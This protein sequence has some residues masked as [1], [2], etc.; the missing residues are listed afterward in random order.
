MP[1]LSLE[2]VRISLEYMAEHTHPSLTSI[3]ALSRSGG[4]SSDDAPAAIAFGSVNE[5]RLLSDYFSP[6]GG[7]EEKPFFVPFG[8]GRGVTHW[9]NGNYPGRSLQR[10]RTDRP[11]I[12]RQDPANNKRWS[13]GANF[14]ANIQA[15]PKD[16]IGDLPIVVAH[17][18][19][20]CFRKREIQSLAEIVELF[21]AEFRLREL[22]ALGPIFSDQI[23]D[24]LSTLQLL[25]APLDDGEL[26]QLLATYEPE[27]SEEEDDETGEKTEQPSVSGAHVYRIPEAP[28]NWDLAPSDLADL[29][30]LQGLEEAAFRTVAA[31]RSGMHVILTGAP[32][33]GKTKLADC[34]CRKAGFPAWT[35][36]ATDQWTTFET[37]G[38]YFP[39]P[40]E[41]SSG[42]RLDFLPGAVVE[43]LEKGRCLIID[44]INRAD[45]D[46][47]FGE[48]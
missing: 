45:I 26:L 29:C 20:W 27:R 12:F 28:G 48:L 24:A 44:E 41:D 25:N 16:S 47:A 4:V 46:K 9:R 34:I 37:I 2:H 8:T 31:L 35:V 38:G 32:G 13:F 30:G 6:I 43:S 40:S 39:S 21:I 10:Q 1:F 36:P 42:D 19:V 15:K 5:R 14:L 3:L 22:G 18:A 33:T 17:L 7:P 11:E 23:P